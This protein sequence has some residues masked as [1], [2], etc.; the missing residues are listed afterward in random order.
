LEIRRNKNQ[1]GLH[2]EVVCFMHV[3]GGIAALS[4]G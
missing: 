3:V 2:C 4:L 1:C